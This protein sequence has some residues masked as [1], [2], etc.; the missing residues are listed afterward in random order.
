M[1][2]WL[3][4]PLL[5]NFMANLQFGAYELNKLAASGK[6]WISTIRTIKCAKPLIELQMLLCFWNWQLIWPNNQSFDCKTIFPSSNHLIMDLCSDTCPI[7]PRSVVCFRA[8]TNKCSPIDT[9]YRRVSISLETASKY[10]W[11]H[12][13]DWTQKMQPSLL[14][15]KG[16]PQQK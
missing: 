15:W 14:Y 10:S 11:L 13:I 6:Y 9:T 1:W 16:L 8:F 12:W 4:V 3:C 5:H 7:K 2:T